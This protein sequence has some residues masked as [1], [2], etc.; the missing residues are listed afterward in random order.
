MSE[1][2]VKARGSGDEY[3][4]SVDGCVNSFKPEDDAEPPVLPAGWKIE[5]ERLLC[6]DHA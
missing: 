6:P 1:W 5:G 3:T 4:C 2:Y